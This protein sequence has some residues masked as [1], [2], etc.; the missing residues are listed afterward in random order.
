[1]SL[2]SA[3]SVD[4]DKMQF[5]VA[6][7]V[8]LHCLPKYPFKGVSSI[9]RVNREKNYINELWKVEIAD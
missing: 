3:N 5:L 4:P 9:Q 2:N 6:F 8:G 1:M 7:H